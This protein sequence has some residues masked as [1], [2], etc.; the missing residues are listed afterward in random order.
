V[1]TQTLELN[2]FT[3]IYHFEHKESISLHLNLHRV[4]NVILS[5]IRKQADTAKDGDNSV[6]DVFLNGTDYTGKKVQIAI[7][8]FS[9]ASKKLK[10]MK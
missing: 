6:R 9:D 3:R 7:T 5:K 1:N 2:G 10:A 8:L 4:E